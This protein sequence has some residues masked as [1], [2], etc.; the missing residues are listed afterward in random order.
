MSN[1]KYAYSL[2]SETYVGTYDSIDEARLEASCFDDHKTIWVGTI[3]KPD[4]AKLTNI[5]YLLQYIEESVSD[6]MDW[7]G[8]DDELININDK[9]LFEVKIKTAIREH[10][11]TNYFSVENANEYQNK[12]E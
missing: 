12:L 2:D 3:V 8:Y 5:D 4:I 11:T 7:F 6:E 9:A 10:I 1:D